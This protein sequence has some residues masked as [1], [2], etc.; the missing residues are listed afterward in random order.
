AYITLKTA[1]PANINL[2]VYGTEYRFALQ[3]PGERNL[4]VILDPL[5]EQ[6]YSFL[7]T[8]SV[9]EAT[10]ASIDVT[11]GKEVYCLLSYVPAGGSGSMSAQ[12]ALQGGSVK[13]AECGFTA[14]S[15][16]QFSAWNIDGTD[17]RPGSSVTLTK[18][19][20][21][22]A[23]WVD[24]PAEEDDGFPVWIVAVLVVVLLISV[25]AVTMVMRNR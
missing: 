23:V 10:V 9:D 6:T 21:A 1:P 2:I 18:D 15:G 3:L 11:V 12:S 4:E 17:Y 8:N 20:A 7:L 19:L 13:L 16:K 24:R 25:A 14:P 5:K 22:T